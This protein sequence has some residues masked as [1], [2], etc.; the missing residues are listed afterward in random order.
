MGDLSFLK[1]C[2]N[3]SQLVGMI[4]VTVST[5]VSN[6]FVRTMNKDLNKLDI[7]RRIWWIIS[8]ERCHGGH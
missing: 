5:A 2:T 7:Y 4:V 3:C 6:V 1:E 8:L